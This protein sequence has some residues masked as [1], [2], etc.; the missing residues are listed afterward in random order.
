MT[1]INSQPQFTN[2]HCSIHDLILHEYGWDG[3]EP[4]VFT[5][6]QCLACIPTRSRPPKVIRVKETRRGFYTT[7]W[8]PWLNDEKIKRDFGARIIRYLV[9]ELKFDRRTVGK[10]SLRELAEAVVGA[11]VPTRWDGGDVWEAVAEKLR[12]FENDEAYRGKKSRS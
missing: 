11:P 2:E 12:Q 3:E 6:P 7:A 5:S 10:M 8:T 1:T 4:E 9:K